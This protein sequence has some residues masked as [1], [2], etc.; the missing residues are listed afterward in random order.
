M[1]EL[2][3]CQGLGAGVRVFLSVCEGV[4]VSE[5]AVLCGGFCACLYLSTDLDMYMIL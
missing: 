1:G 4:C 2:K 5:S 3:E